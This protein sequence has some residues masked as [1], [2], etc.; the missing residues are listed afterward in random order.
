MFCDV[1]RSGVITPAQ[2]SD[3]FNINGHSSAISKAHYQRTSMEDATQR[4]IAAYSAVNGDS[5]A[6]SS[7]PL[8]VAV[9]TQQPWG[10]EH[11]VQDPSAKRARW[12]EAEFVILHAVTDDLLRKDA[13][14]YQP[15]LM[16][17]ALQT[18]RRSP[19]YRK[20]FHH[21]HIMKTDRLRTGYEIMRRR[22]AARTPDAD[23]HGSEDLA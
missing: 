9:A 4:A 23:S 12:D 5:S 3:C 13:V 11:S 15:L 8:Q 16:H 21:R 6:A 18:I 20:A 14:R 10:T 1:C 17:H 2:L 22:L 7:A 19:S